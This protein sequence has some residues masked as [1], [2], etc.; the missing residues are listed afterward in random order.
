MKT[1][2][3]TAIFFFLFS[4]VF[5]VTAFHHHLTL[6]ADSKLIGCPAAFSSNLNTTSIFDKTI[7]PSDDNDLLADD[8]LD[9]DDSFSTREKTSSEDYVCIDFTSYS[10]NLH[11]FCNDLPFRFYRTDL[12]HP[13]RHFIS[14][15]VFRL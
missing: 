4:G 10:Y 6:S 7:P 14:L 3:L 12:N 9:D 11:H 2:K 15:R 1:F 5:G 13:H 8:S